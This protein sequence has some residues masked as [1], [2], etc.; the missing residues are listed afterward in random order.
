MMLMWRTRGTLADYIPRHEFTQSSK[1]NSLQNEKKDMP[2]EVDTNN[3][4]R[5]RI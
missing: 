2:I 5:L 4:H 1:H 3:E